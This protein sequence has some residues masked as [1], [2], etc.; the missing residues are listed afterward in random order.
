MGKQKIIFRDLGKMEYQA[1]WDYQ[2][3]LLK[4]NVKRKSAFRN[5]E[6][7]AGIKGTSFNGSGSALSTKSPG[8]FTDYESRTQ[9]AEL[10]AQH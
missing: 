6:S 9:N 3:S 10:N 5:Q 8:T 1:A 4:E 2:E 7:E